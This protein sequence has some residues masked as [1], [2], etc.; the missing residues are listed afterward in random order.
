M[1]K[2]SCIANY[3]LFIFCVLSLIFV[4]I[5]SFFSYIMNY[6]EV[7][8]RTLFKR[9]YDSLLHSYFLLHITKWST[10]INQ[11]SYFCF[12]L[13]L[14]WW[15]LRVKK[16]SYQQMVTKWFNIP[17]CLIYLL[18]DDI[19][20]LSGK[21]VVLVSWLTVAWLVCAVVF[22]VM[23]MLKNKSEISNK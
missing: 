20:D 16:V 13:A 7:K 15:Y 9:Y 19:F 18:D 22:A 2:T 3:T 14:F 6:D 11:F 23:P 21:T 8:V 17:L 10:C 1:S 4:Y 12:F 5:T